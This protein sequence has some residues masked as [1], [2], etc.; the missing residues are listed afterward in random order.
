MFDVPRGP[1]P[2]RARQ[3]REKTLGCGSGRRLWVGKVGSRSDLQV[4]L[5]YS[6]CHQLDRQMVDDWMMVG[7]AHLQLVML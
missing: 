1:P 7:F 4:F 3:L 2:R 6:W 5:C